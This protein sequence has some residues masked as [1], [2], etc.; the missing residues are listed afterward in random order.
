[1]RA[2]VV[3]DARGGKGATT[4]SEKEEPFLTPPILLP[5]SLSAGEPHPP[6]SPHGCPHTGKQSIGKKPTQANKAEAKSPR[7]QTKHPHLHEHGVQDIPEVIGDRD[8]LRVLHRLVLDHLHP[9]GYGAR[10]MGVQGLAKHECERGEGAK[11]SWLLDSWFQNPS[12]L[13]KPGTA[14]TGWAR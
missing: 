4:D 11:R 3:E 10:S 6:I 12:P 5:P 2:R 14:C 9:Q 1:M 7:R 8:V 13:H